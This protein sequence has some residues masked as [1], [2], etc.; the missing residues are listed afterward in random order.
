MGVLKGRPK[1]PLVKEPKGDKRLKGFSVGATEKWEHDV[2]KLVEARYTEGLAGFPRLKIMAM[3]TADGDVLGLCAWH[4]RQPQYD[5]PGRQMIEP[6]YIHL[7]GV[8]KQFRGWKSEAGCRLGS[9]LLLGAMR[10]IT[11][12]AARLK[13][14]QFGRSSIRA[15]RIAT[16]YSSAMD[17]V[18]SRNRRAII[19]GTDPMAFRSSSS[20]HA[21]GC[22]TAHASA[23]ATRT[24]S[25][26]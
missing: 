9:E 8:S 19:G 11:L 7:I 15:T 2:N 20:Y 4:P 21:Q 10:K 16:I 3:T 24:S 18:S 22:Q 26:S 23:H 6:P 13:C 25:G 17:S 14:P 5:P 12:A 1:F